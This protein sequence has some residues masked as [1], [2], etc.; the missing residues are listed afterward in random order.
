MAIQGLAA[1]PALFRALSAGRAVASAASASASAGQ[2]AS[3]GRVA[4][5]TNFAAKDLF[6]QAFQKGGKMIDPS[7]LSKQHDATASAER[8][9]AA[10]EDAT[11]K[12]RSLSGAAR[13]GIS[14][15]ILLP[16]AAIAFSKAMLNSQESMRQF[17]TKT[18]LAFNR[19]EAGR[20][21]RQQTRAAATEA[22]TEGLADA[23]NSLEKTLAPVMSGLTNVMTIIATHGI[24]AVEGL[25]AVIRFINPV[26]NAAMK[27][28]ETQEAEAA[29]RASSVAFEN[30]DRIAEAGR[31]QRN[32][33]PGGGK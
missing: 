30:L 23:M 26:V 31:N 18:A 28:M 17:S 33:F 22:T 32:R 20:F 19:L 27:R 5:Q 3:A 16:P 8:E 29:K 11:E 24:K 10:K 1:I 13:K 14:S 15:L 4:G 2:A 12:L 9:T 25:I 7:M 21:S 6:K